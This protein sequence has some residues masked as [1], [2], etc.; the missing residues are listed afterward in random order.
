MTDTQ[1]KSS[2]YNEGAQMLDLVDKYFKAAII[3]ILGEWKEAM[4]K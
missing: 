2:Q 1:V 4:L 3:N